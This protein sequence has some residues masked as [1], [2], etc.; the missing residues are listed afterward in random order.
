MKHFAWVQEMYRVWKSVVRSFILEHVDRG[1]EI[2]QPNPHITPEG[3]L[4]N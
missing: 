1:K 2:L 3:K 4:Y